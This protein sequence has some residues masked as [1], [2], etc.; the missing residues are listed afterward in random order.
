MDS[1]SLLVTQFILFP[2]PAVTWQP[3]SIQISNV[4]T[5]QEHRKEIRVLRPDSA[6]S[7]HLLY[8][9]SIFCSATWPAVTEATAGL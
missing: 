9:L 1:F 3:A 8:I 2:L 7:L 6:T 5:E 4:N